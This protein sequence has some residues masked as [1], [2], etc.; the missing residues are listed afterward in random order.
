MT[1]ADRIVVLKQGEIEQVGTP[2]E[3]Y[4]PTRQYFLWPALSAVRR[5]NFLPASL[6][7]VA[8][9]SPDNSVICPNMMA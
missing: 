1:L 8:C 2:A 5:R 4:H 3:V 7:T 9:M 6:K